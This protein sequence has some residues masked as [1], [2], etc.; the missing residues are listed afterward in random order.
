METFLESGLLDDMEEDVLLDL[1]RVISI[2][3]QNKLSIPRS[4]VLIHQAMEKYGDWLAVQDIPTP[5][6]RQ[7]WK[8]KARSPVQSPAEVL[9]STKT[10]RRSSPS[11]VTSPDIRP[12]P[13]ASNV[14]DIFT[15]DDEV[16]TPTAAAS[17]A[18][19]P[20]NSRPMTP[21]DLSASSKAPVWKSRTVETE[22]CVCFTT[23]LNGHLRRIRIDLRS[24]MAETAA[25][26]TKASIRPSPVVLGSDA[27]ASNQRV[28]TSSA[29]SAT[30]PRALQLTASDSPSTPSPRRVLESDKTSTAVVQE[31][32]HINIGS[33]AGPSSRLV[34]GQ[35]SPTPQRTRSAKVITPVKAQVASHNVQ[36]KTSQCVYIFLVISDGNDS[37]IGALHGQQLWDSL[38][39]HHPRPSHPNLAPSLC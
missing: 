17:G 14:D 32:G 22:R 27:T 31:Q 5:R 35:D 39:L 15:M 10:T 23:G 37:Y 24:I 29:A 30:L 20:K 2:K 38:P 21:L 28:T 36:R 12:T 26:T 4:G 8:W 16:C 13:S 9:K 34:A 3:Q 11:P 1:S 18:R 19:T 7:P 33:P 25:T 6:I